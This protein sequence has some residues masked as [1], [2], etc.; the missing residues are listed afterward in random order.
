M[1]Y[2]VLYTS[3]VDHA[4]LQGLCSRVLQKEGKRDA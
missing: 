4:L 1:M 2:I 3:Y